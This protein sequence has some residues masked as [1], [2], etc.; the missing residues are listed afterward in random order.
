MPLRSMTGF[1]RTQGSH[2]NFAWHWELR[3]VNGRSLDIRLRLPAGSETLEASARDLCAKR[4]ARGNITV[5]LN[6]TRSG[7]GTVIRLNEPALLQLTAA[8]RRARE[9]SDASPATLDGLLAMRGVLEVGEAILAQE[10]EP[11]PSRA[12]CSI[13]DYRIVC[14]AS[15]G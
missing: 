12:A 2:A 9:L 8:A 10:F 13:C 6:L 7:S 1:A 15:E 11:T 3:S 5:S 4:L 14:P